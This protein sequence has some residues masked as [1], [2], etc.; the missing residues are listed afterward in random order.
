MWEGDRNDVFCGYVSCYAGVWSKGADANMCSALSERIELF[1]SGNDVLF[2]NSAWKYD[3]LH[4][5]YYLLQYFYFYDILYL[6]RR[7]M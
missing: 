5:E 1:M 4:R 3:G 6:Y 7:N 2:R